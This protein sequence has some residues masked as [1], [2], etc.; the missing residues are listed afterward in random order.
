M[1]CCAVFFLRR[2]SRSDKIPSDGFRLLPNRGENVAVRYY[3][4]EYDP[5][6]FMQVVTAGAEKI[7]PDEPQHPAVPKIRRGDIVS[8][9][10][11][12][13]NERIVFDVPK[14]H[15]AR[16]VA[17]YVDFRYEPTDEK[18]GGSAAIR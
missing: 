11:I 2:L 6:P 13:K 18:R 17:L 16:N 15:V 5:S 10:M 14:E 1:S 4:E 9:Y 8:V 3:L 12:R 7:T